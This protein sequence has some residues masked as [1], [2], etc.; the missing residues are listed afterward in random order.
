MFNRKACNLCQ[1]CVDT[2]PKNAIEIVGREYSVDDVMR[3]VMR[4]CAYYGENGGVTLSG[5]EPLQQANFAIALMQRLKAAGIHVALDTCGCCDEKTFNEAIQYTDLLLFDLKQMNPEKHKQYTGVDNAQILSNFRLVAKRGKKIIVRIP[6][7]P[8]INDDSENV[9]TL[10]DFLKPYPKVQVE[11]LP[12]HAYGVSKY[13]AIGIR[14]QLNDLQIPTT[15]A[16]E[17]MKASLSQGG[18]KLITG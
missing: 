8:G 12:Y 2:C 15:D 16:M 9:N 14:Y 4:D 1:R 5:G 3:V 11:A 7:I 10:I 18:L 6:I 13:E 17:R